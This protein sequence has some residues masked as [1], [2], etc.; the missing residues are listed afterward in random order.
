MPLVREVALGTTF[1]GVSKF[2]ALNSCIPP[3]LSIGK[4]AIAITIT[5]IPPSHCRSDRQTKIPGGESSIFVSIVDPVVVIPDMDSKKEF[6]KFK[7]I[8]LK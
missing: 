4:I 5:P 8:S 7:F 1:S 3:T 2:S 6:V